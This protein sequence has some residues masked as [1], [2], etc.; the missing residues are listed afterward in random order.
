MNSKGSAHIFIIMV[1]LVSALVA[2]VAYSS[3]TSRSV[4]VDSVDQKNP[5]PISTESDNDT[6]EQE[7]DSTIVQDVEFD[8]NLLNQEA[9]TL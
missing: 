9:D 8:I 1:L 6:L 3:T 2:F 5:L 7:I 4:V